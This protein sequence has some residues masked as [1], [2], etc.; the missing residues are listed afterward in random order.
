VLKG[1]RQDFEILDLGKAACAVEL[2]RRNVA[3]FCLNG[4]T[5]GPSGGSGL[6]DGANERPRYPAAPGAWHD[7]Q[8]PELPRTA[9]PQRRGK[10][11]GGG[12]AS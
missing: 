1:Q 8:I 12:Q 3:G 5:D 9:Q 7:G 10:R 11:H 6:A 4:Q 2:E